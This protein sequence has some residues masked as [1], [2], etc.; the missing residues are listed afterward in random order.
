MLYSICGLE[1][2]KLTEN[3]LAIGERVNNLTRLF[4]LREGLKAIDDA[5]PDRFSDVP[6]SEGPL[7]GCTV[8]IGQMMEEYYHL[9]GWDKEGRPLPDKLEELNLVKEGENV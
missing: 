5:L 1:G 4:N 3:L 2:L 8:D 9:R 6:I 7:K